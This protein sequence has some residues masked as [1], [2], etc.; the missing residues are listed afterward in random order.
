MAVLQHTGGEQHRLGRA[1]LEGCEQALQLGRTGSAALDQLDAE[2]AGAGA[3]LVA[4]AGRG[5]L[6][7]AKAPFDHQIP[8]LDIAQIAH[9]QREC[10]GK[11]RVERCC[12]IG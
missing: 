4:P 12:A 2:H 10:A 7:I 6:V 1:R 8:A 9:A 3:C 11:E 5:R